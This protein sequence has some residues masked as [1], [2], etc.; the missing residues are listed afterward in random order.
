[1]KKMKSKRF[2]AMVATLL[3]FAFALAACGSKDDTTTQGA[4]SQAVD[5]TPVES[6]AEP[7]E[8][9]APEARADGLP[10]YTG[11]P[12]EISFGWW[13]NDERAALQQEVIDEFQKAYPEI[14]VVGQPNGGTP[15]HLA[16]IDPQLASGAGPDLFTL[17]GNWPDYVQYLEV[18]NQYEGN[19]L[20]I[21]DPAKFDASGITAVSAANGDLYGVSLGTNA[22][23]MIYNQTVLEAAGVELPKDDWTWEEFIQY[24]KDIKDKLPEGVYPFADNATNQANFISYFL[25]QNGETIYDGTTTTATE[26]TLTKWFDIWEGLRADGVVPD[27]DTTATYAETGADTS[28]ITAGKALFGIIWSNQLDGYQGATTDEISLVAP[29]AGANK[30]LVLQLSQ[31]ICL[32]K[33]SKNKEAAVLFMNYLTT[34]VE[35]GRI[36]GTS[37][38]VPASPAVREA[39]SGEASET[40][41]K[42]YAYYDVLD[43]I[44]T[45]PQGLNLPNDQEFVDGLAKI[46]E[47]LRAGRIDSAAAAAET[48]KLMKE[49]IAK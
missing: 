46:G 36:M 33:N 31:T 26:E 29:P 28:A 6:A 24:G 30:A 49:L 35:A 40:S 9:P 43:T 10:T 14:T 21:D 23:A 12:A 32:N 37:R 22:L 13:G 1:M 3:V 34:S 2:T 8:E 20:Q 15:D 19:L 11:G 41:K 42:I 16:I 27:K 47:R 48:L 25:T 4:S 5:T 45:V 38:G 39:I 7:A 18:L 17:G 44:G